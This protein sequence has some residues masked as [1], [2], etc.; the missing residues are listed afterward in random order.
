MEDKIF[1][2][3]HKNPDTDSICAA[4]SYAYL[5]N[6]IEKTDRYQAR[7]AG[8]INE[9]TEFVL[10]YFGKEA[11]LYMP[12][13]GTQVKDLTIDDVEGAPDDVTIRLAWDYMS[14]SGISALPIMKEDGT[15]EGMITDTDITRY[16]MDAYSKTIMSEAK[17][18]YLDIAETINGE[19]V[20]GD[21]EAHFEEG[22]VIV[23]AASPEHFQHYIKPKDLVILADRADTQLT[24]IEEGATAIVI[25]L[26]GE[27]KKIVRMAAQAAGT[28][29]ITTKFDTYTVAR[30]INQAIPVKHL[31]QKEGVVSFK[32]DDFLDD[33]R[34]TMSKLRRPSY[35]VMNN[36]GQYVGMIGSQNLLS[37]K[38]KHV[39]LVDH[40]ELSQAVDNLEQAE[41]VE[42]VDHHRVGTVE[43]INPVYFRGEPVGCTCTIIYSMFHEYGI[44]IPKDIAGLMMSAIISDT[45]LFRSPTCTPRDQVAGIALSKIAEVNP[46]DYAKQMFRAGSALGNKT[47]EEI[48]HQDFKKFIFGDTTFGVGQISSMDTDELYEIAEKLR[49]QLEIEAAKSGMSM[50]FFMLTNIIDED[51]RLMCYG[52]DAPEVVQVAYNTQIGDDG[53]AFLPKVVSRKKQLI[54]AFMSALQNG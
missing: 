5:K 25:C 1:V 8:Q 21:P 2:V 44:E 34:E 43:T 19:V 38:K 51:T 40:T 30:L 42:I 6:Q 12:N 36:R 28:V 15:L 31:M 4:I 24:A 10:K 23:G 13:V 52:K 11:P 17:T 20:V 26:T 37:A 29:V 14:E 33:I 39:I 27:V 32:E 7:R 48:L 46:G 53:I 41:I 3:G 50:V 54:P 35:P 18:K 49:P 22:R 47:P 16:F 9:E 45:L